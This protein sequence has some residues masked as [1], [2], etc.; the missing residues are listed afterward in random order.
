MK[1]NTTKSIAALLSAAAILSSTVLAGPGPQD[2][3]QAAP[4]KVPTTTV[5][6]GGTRKAQASDFRATTDTPRATRLVY[7]AHGGVIVL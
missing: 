5:A 2:H 6:F 1:T 4:A 3:S 7:G